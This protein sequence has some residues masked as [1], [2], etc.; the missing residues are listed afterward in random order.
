M[1][2]TSDQK[3]VALFTGATAGLGE[4]ILKAYARNHENSRI[5]F[6]GRNDVA[7]QQIIGDVRQMWKETSQRGEGEGDIIFVKADLTLLRN[8][9]D[10]VQEILR[11]EGDNAKLDFLC[12]SQGILTSRGRI[13]KWSCFDFSLIMAVGLTSSLLLD[14]LKAVT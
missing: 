6:V 1:T 13:G 4:A 8:A 5:Y 10:V 11:R 12:M 14:L 2:I 9:R 7:A 3:P